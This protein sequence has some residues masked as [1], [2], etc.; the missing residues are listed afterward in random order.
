MELLFSTEEISGVEALAT[1]GLPLGT[2]Y[3]NALNLNVCTRH[4]D[5]ALLRWSGICVAIDFDRCWVL[6]WIDGRQV[7]DEPLV[8]AFDIH[9]YNM[10]PIFNTKHAK[11]RTQGN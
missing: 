8:K 4:S 10:H 5:N 6:Y 2:R 11:H 9:E 1:T 7:A 3:K